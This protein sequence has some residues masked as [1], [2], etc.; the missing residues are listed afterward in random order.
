MN[1]GDLSR[2]ERARLRWRKTVNVIMLSLTGVA[3]LG[4]VSV[5]F[6]ILGYLIVNGEYLGSETGENDITQQWMVVHAKNANEARVVRHGKH[7]PEKQPLMLRRLSHNCTRHCSAEFH[8]STSLPTSA[9]R[10][11]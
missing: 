10:C 4:V 5:L 11:P 7:R 9:N 2:M 6:L 8:N 1:S 3:A